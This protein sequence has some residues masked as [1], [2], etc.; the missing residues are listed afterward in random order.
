[1]LAMLANPTVQLL[2]TFYVSNKNYTFIKVTE[3]SNNCSDMVC[4]HNIAL[5]CLLAVCLTAI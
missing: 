1:M 4:E 3:E 2:E 5:V